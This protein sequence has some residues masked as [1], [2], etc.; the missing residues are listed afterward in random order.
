[1]EMKLTD[2]EILSFINEDLPYFDL[3]TSLQNIDKNAT[4]SIFSRQNIIVSC[5][6]VATR[7][8]EL[9]G[10][11]TE[12]CI[13]NSFEATKKE[14]IIKIYGSYNDVH[15]AW[16]LAQILLE[17]TCQIATYTNAMCK[18][19]KAVNK[20]CEILATRKNFPFAKKICLKAV[21][22]GG[23]K[24][25]RLGLNDSILFFK[26][27]IKAYKNYDEFLS[28]IPNFKA[29]MPERKIAVECENL[30]ECEAVLKAG[31]DVVQCDKFSCTELEKAI[32]L[33][34]KFAPNS[35]IIASGGINLTNIT[36]IAATRIDAIATSAMYTQGMC[37]MTSL[38]EII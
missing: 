32:F 14:P 34:N 21:L 28:E 24:V 20:K 38:I 33:R 13:Q 7:I 11:K 19:A 29:K 6:D 26:N 16:K 3:T 8:A 12:I 2:V 36:D 18:A 35:K 17:Y 4:L 31:S 30:S 37:D 25:H 22:E 10:C 1:M 23:G 27:H 9:L 15:S 5:V